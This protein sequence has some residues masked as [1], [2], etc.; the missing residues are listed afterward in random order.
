MSILYERY[1]EGISFT[2]EIKKDIERFLVNL[3]EYDTYQHTISV[4][5][6]AVRIANM[7]NL[8]NDLASQAAFLHDISNVI[9]KN[10]MMS[11]AESSGI[12]ILEE[13][14]S[15]HR[16][17]HQKLS[18]DMAK[19]I[20]GCTNDI[21]LNAI[22]CHTTL[23]ARSSLLDKVLFVSDKISWNLP[24]DHPYQEK[25]REK[26]ELLDLNGAVLIYLNH[27]WEQ[28]DKLKLVHPWLIEAREEMF[29]LS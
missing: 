17:I 15:Y 21:V 20:F 18:K 1:T 14:Y 25:M 6:E 28:R 10:S 3:N 22:E 2:G 29:A 11:I 16:I 26:I 8:D 12:D 5:D 7:F 24:G 27:V 4:A 19:K 23:K 13:E 9:P